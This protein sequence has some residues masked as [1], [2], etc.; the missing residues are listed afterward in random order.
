MKMKAAQISKPGGDF[1]LVEREIPEPGSGQIRV[2]V[3]ACGI[4]HSDMLVK[5]GIWPGLQFPRVPG[6]EIA[7][8]IDA[9][10]NL[11]TRHA[12][13]LKPR[14]DT[15]LNEHIA[16]ANATRLHFHANLPGAWLR[17]IAFHQFPIPAR[18]TDLRR[19]HFHNVLTV[20]A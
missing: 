2:K 11:V 3:E 1:E 14:P 9:A 6:H 19:L 16:V 12:R 10:C 15:L 13:K 17:N 8:R 7:G 4:C 5:E 20:V 18:F